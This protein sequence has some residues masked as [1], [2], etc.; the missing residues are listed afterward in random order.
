MCQRAVR[1]L[2]NPCE[3]CLVRKV[4]RLLAQPLS[5]LCWSTRGGMVGLPSAP[6]KGRRWLMKKRILMLLTVV[7]LMMVMVAMS[8]APAFAA[9]YDVYGCRTGSNFATQ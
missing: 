6:T 8:V 1:R 2:C 7:A 9:T 4:A 3:R 5:Y